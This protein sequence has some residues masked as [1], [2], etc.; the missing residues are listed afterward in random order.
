MVEVHIPSGVPVRVRVGACAFCNERV[1]VAGSKRLP[2]HCSLSCAAKARWRRKG[3]R[4]SGERKTY[5][6]CGERIGR[7]RRVCDKC[8]QRRRGHRLICGVLVSNDELTRSQ[9]EASFTGS[10]YER[11]VKASGYIRRA[12]RSEYRRSGRPQACAV[13]EESEV[14]EIAHIQAIKNHTPTATVA[15]M[16]RAS[17]LIALC[18]T[19]HA[20]QERGKLDLAP[21]LDKNG[22]GA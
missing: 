1:E 18:P 21:H 9:L 11:F 13:C 15:H 8:C 17:N 20:L 16:N 19:H 14:V 5:C 3:C 6:H 22:P 4:T 2:A 7:D 10:E 12:A